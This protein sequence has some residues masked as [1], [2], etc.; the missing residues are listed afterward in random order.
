YNIDLNAD[1]SSQKV[2]AGDGV[3]YQDITFKDW[4]GTCSNGLQRGPV[5]VLC[6]DKVPCMGIVV[7]G[8]EVWTK[9]QNAYGS[10]ACLKAGSGSGYAVV[11]STISTAPS[12]YA[13]APKM[14]NDL[15]VSF[16]L[17]AS[18][19]IPAIPTTFFPGAAPASK[20][21]GG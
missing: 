4:R 15:T 14:P 7:E 21:L 2:A 17:T 8:F 5:Q 18:I 10:G 3:L 19:P 6:P 13:S 11:T 20:L 16:A 1:W 12:G 9:S